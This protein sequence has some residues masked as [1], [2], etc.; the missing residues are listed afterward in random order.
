[1]LNLVVLGSGSREY[2]I[3]D[4][5]IQDSR[6]EI[7]YPVSNI[8][9][10]PKNDAILYN[11]PEVSLI[12]SNFQPTKTDHYNSFIEFCK[13][14]NVD[15]VIIGPEQHLVDGIVDRL[16][17]HNIPAF[18]PHQLA[19]QLEGSKVFSK[20]FMDEFN[21]PTAPYQTFNNIA[22]E[23]AKLFINSNWIDTKKYVLKA[24]GL[25]G[26]K[27]VLLP[28]TKEECLKEIDNMLIHHKFGNAS[29]SIIIEER[30]EGTEVSILGFCNGKD[31][32][33]MPPAQ[34]YKKKKD[35]NEG[36]NT[37]GMGCHCPVITLTSTELN[38]LQNQIIPLIKHFKYKGILYCGLMKSYTD[39]NIYFL[40]F[41]CRFGDPETQVILPLLESSLY[42]VMAGCCQGKSFWDINIIWRPGF[43]SNVILSHQDYP[44]S[45]LSSPI[46]I[47]LPDTNTTNTISGLLTVKTYWGNVSINNNTYYTTGG[48]VCSLVCYHPSDYYQTLF[49]IYN[50]AKL[51]D[52]PG[53]Y[54]R[55]DIG[56]EFLSYIN[57]LTRQTQPTKK[58]N[59]AV[60]GSTNGT[61][62]EEVLQYFHSKSNIQS[63]ENHI[64]SPEN[65]INVS[66]IISNRKNAGILKKAQNYGI[67]YLYLPSKKG[68]SIENYETKMINI[69]RQ[70]DIDLVL[71][72]GY[73]KIVSPI[74]LSEYPNA[75]LNIHPSLLPKYD[76]MMDLDIHQQVINNKE[77]STGCT[78]HYVTDK[79]DSG[80]ILF[81]R[82]LILDKLISNTL[83][84]NTIDTSSTL[85]IEVQ[86]LESRCLIDAI[87]LFYSSSKIDYK[88]SGV[89][90]DKGN[91]LVENIKS[92]SESTKKYIGGFGANFEIPLTP[93]DIVNKKIILSAG[94]DGVGTKLYLTS[95]VKK[96]DTIGIDLVAMSVNDLLVGG[97]RP[98]FFLDYLAVDSLQPDKCRELVKGIQ[99]GCQLANI[100]LIGGET[101]EMKGIYFK[102]KFDMAG[103]AVGKLEYPIT[104]PVT[105]NNLIYGIASSGIHSNGYSLVRKLL[106]KAPFPVPKSKILELLTPTKIYT[107]ALELFEKYPTQIT[108]MAHITGGGFT[109]NIPRVLPNDLTFELQQW[110]L[111][112]VFQWIQDTA[113]LSKGEMMRTFNCGYG[114]V[115]ISNVKLNEP[116]LDLIGKIV[117][118][119]NK[120]LQSNK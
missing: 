19:S 14:N 104:T 100:P 31:I 32:A 55:R 112:L 50:Y 33:F 5:L 37:G 69:L 107:E 94:T 35:N 21:I 34:D 105:E 29:D 18:G 25:A 76:N 65:N 54:Y 75:I 101:A 36:L 82:Q 96:Y 67:S 119:N 23:D 79:V 113:L 6:D 58:M 87:Y 108:G 90:I 95:D 3:I 62:L 7:Y 10:Y 109:D 110:D 24:D 68:Q 42:Q 99:T 15:M 38:T 84:S 4:K 28:D 115:I 78:L 80:D 1:M 52:Y 26:G 91:E 102:D 2:A 8:Y 92:L 11:Y 70:Y 13:N 40:E 16:E 66:V 9:S 63:V 88:S 44:S 120:N 73:M 106:S 116:Y 117:K 72:V 22:I 41:N 81:Q 53:I 49:S 118:K 48:R 17:K 12:P 103:F 61:S 77:Y 57:T 59:I 39:D 46:P 43:V 51:F 74:L 71:L 20:S 83:I 47:T 64:P 56:N 85:K 27:G 97:I 98:L 114:L 60:L 111:P 93:K 45:K 86:K 30:L 89:D